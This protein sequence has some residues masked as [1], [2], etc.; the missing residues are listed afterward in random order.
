MNDFIWIA[1]VF[2]TSTGYYFLGHSQ[3]KLS[4]IRERMRQRE[5]WYQEM[6]ETNRD[7]ENFLRQIA[8]HLNIDLPPRLK[9]VPPEEQN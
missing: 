7:H 1:I 2:F 3:G 9:V 5:E 6:L 4:E 8:E